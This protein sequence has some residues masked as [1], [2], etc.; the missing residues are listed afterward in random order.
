[1]HPK[2]QGWP[3]RRTSQGSELAFLILSRFFK[4]IHDIASK[5]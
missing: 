4:K 1:M 5:Y 3:E 2:P